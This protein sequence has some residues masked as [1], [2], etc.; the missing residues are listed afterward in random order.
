MTFNCS[1]ISS[2]STELTNITLYGNWSGGWHANETKSLTGTS[3]STSFTK[4][5]PPTSAT[6]SWNCLVYNNETNSDWFDLNYTFLIDRDVPQVT[7]NSPTGTMA[8]VTPLINI[9]SSETGTIR[10][11]LDNGANTTLC[12][13]CNNSQSNFAYVLEGA[14]TIY[15][16]ANDSVGNLN[17]TLSSFTVNMNQNYY[18]GF[19]DNSSIDTWNDISWNIGNISFTGGISTCITR[20]HMSPR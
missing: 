17:S 20:R 6:Y 3:N 2:P 14:H 8:D 16:F 9:S 1:A 11:N 19:D 13:A 10:Y 18:D 7:I 12:T 15:I 5:L 4:T